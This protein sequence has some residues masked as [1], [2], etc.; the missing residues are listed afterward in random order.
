MTEPSE[1]RVFRVVVNDDEQYSIWPA[2]KAL[3]NGWSPVG[4]EGPKRTCLK[5]IQKVWTDMRPRSVRQ[6][7]ERI[8]EPA[9]D[10]GGQ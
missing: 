2:D 10:P 4:T 7:L 5:Y 9:T 1:T 6:Q 8:G 3:P